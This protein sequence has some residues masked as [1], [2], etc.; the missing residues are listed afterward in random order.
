MR[1]LEKKNELPDGWELAKIKD[2]VFEP[3]QE[4][5]DG[6]FGSNL[7]STEYVEKGIPFIRLQNVSRNQ[8]VNK[9]IKYITKEKSKQLTR[10]NF[11]NQDIVLTK[12]GDPLGEACIVPDYFPN[13]VIVADIIRIRLNHELI[14]KKF[15]MYLINSDKIIQQFK[16]YTKGTTRPRVNLTQVRNFDV[17]IPPL[18]EQQRIVAKIE[19]LFSHLDHQTNLINQNIRLLQSFEKSILRDTFSGKL[20]KV[21]RE[22]HSCGDPQILLNKIKEERKSKNLVNIPEEIPENYDSEKNWR[23]SS[24]GFITQNFDGKRIPVSKTKRKD[25]KGDFPYYGASGI[26]DYVNRPLFK[27]K[28][29]LIGEDGANLLA[30]STPIAFIADGE[31][32]VNNH[33][34]VLQTL[35]GVD[36]EYLS[37]FINSIDLSEWISGTAQPKLNQRNMSKIPIPIPSLEEQEEIKKIIHQN[38]SIIKKQSDTLKKLISH[39]L[40]LKM[41]ILNHAFEGK[42]VPQDPNDE[43]AEILLEKIKQE[44]QQYEEKI[45]KEKQQ[46][47]QKQKTKRSRKNV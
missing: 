17:Q 14:S 44:Q 27:G 18:N 25:M 47:K 41:S 33:A 8:F 30:R 34:H 46:L 9:N 28:Y 45:K 10:H 37:Y 15:L 32:W 21:F 19:E 36:L 13:G 16:K 20:T 4:I 26:I 11:K 3:K 5:V 7:K 29:L 24:L 22:T 39:I 42:L 1:I 31:F 2:L 6:P 12:L 23:F 35:G 43:S 38:L 40:I